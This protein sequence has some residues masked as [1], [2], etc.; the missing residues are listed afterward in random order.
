MYQGNWTCSQCNGSITELPFQPKSEKGLTCRACFMKNKG[1]GVS[2]S[3]GAAT[4]A[5]APAPEPDM[6]SSAEPPHDI[7][8]DAGLAS[9]APPMEGGFEDA[10]PVTPGEKPKFEGNWEC[11][12]CGGAIT[13]LPFQ[14][15]DTSNLK[16]LDCFK[17][18]KG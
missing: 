6:G 1:G 11:A 15:R 3:A 2:A 4:E 5:D 9:E 13:S 8:E 16:C 12:T 17:A 18:S 7:P 14:P 10:T